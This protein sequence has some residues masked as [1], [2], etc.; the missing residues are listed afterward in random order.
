MLNFLGKLLFTLTSVSPVM[1]LMALLALLDEECLYAVVFSISGAG[2]LS[3]CL[4]IFRLV[5]QHSEKMPFSF[6]SIEPADKDS[7]GVL[8]VYLTP[9]LTTS[10]MQFQW[11]NWLITV[12]VIVVLISLSNSLPLNPILNALGWHSYRVSTDE[13]VKYILVTKKHLRNVAKSTTVVEL[14]DYILVDVGGS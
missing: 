4:F 11:M 8:L 12:A 14:A 3:L 9:L 5:R 10:L 2:L 13:Q 7:I 6:D 1:L